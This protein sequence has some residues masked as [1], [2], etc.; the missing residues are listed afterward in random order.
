[1]LEVVNLECQRGDRC[2]F[3]E[4]SFTLQRGELI[5]LHGHNG[6]G[7]TTLLRA[8]CGLI[9]PTSGEIRWQGSAIDSLREEFAA[10]V[11]YIG[12]KGAIKGGLTALENLQIASRLDGFAITEEHAWRALERIGLR[13]FEDLPTRVL[14]QGQKRRVA[15]ARLLVNRAPLWVLDEPFV[16][17]DRAAVGLL[18][19]V[20]ADHVANAGMVM[21]TTH[22]EVSLTTGEVRQLQLGVGALGHA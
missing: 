20:I 13:G 1:M 11:T 9:L 4:L 15:L 19:G 2:L 17:L 5:H 8:L 18:Q 10:N 6:S 16:A 22:Q 7:K 12:H 21:L 14:S 3:S